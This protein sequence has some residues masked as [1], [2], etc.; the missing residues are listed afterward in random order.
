MA[1]PVLAVTIPIVLAVA[2]ATFRQVESIIIAGII[3]L[4]VTTILGRIMAYAE[5]RM[6]QNER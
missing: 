6:K 5:W 3:Y 2:S 4:L 1:A